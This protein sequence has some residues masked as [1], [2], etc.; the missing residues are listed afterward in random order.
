MKFVASMYGR[1]Q[2][3]FNL[4]LKRVLCVRR[5]NG[6][7][8]V[9]LK[10]AVGI[11]IGRVLTPDSDPQNSI[12]TL[13]KRWKSHRRSLLYRVDIFFLSG[14]SPVREIILPAGFRS[15]LNI[16]RNGSA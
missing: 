9:Q 1:T 14:T 13:R 6:G 8:A 11:G 2:G 5:M 10:P 4:Q 16:D 12:A 15:F 3:R 7:G